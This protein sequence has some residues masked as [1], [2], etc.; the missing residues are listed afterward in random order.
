MDGSGTCACWLLLSGRVLVNYD[1]QGIQD[2][3]D[4][5]RQVIWV[6][7]LPV[8]DILTAN[9]KNYSEITIKKQVII[10]GNSQK[11]YSDLMSGQKTHSLPSKRRELLI[12]RL[13]SQSIVRNC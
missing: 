1:L 5:L 4:C 12:E 10:K 3:L 7:N 11:Y 6:W 13:A 2:R 9:S 8:P